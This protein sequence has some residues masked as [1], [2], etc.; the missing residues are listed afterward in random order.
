VFE[1][2]QNISKDTCYPG[3]TY[4]IGDSW[5]LGDWNGATN[6]GEY[7]VMFIEMSATW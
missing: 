3:N 5:K 7:S 4:D 6:G 2:D 1:S